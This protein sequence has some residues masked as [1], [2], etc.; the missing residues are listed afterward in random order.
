MGIS[1]VDMK[2]FNDIGCSA[3]DF[4]DKNETANKS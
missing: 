1:K 2:L 4:F 3:I